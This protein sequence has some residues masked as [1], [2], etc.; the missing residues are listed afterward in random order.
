[1]KVLTFYT[2]RYRK[3]PIKVERTREKQMV[4][5]NRHVPFETVTLTTL[6]RNIELLEDILYNGNLM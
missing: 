6:G 4:D 5:Q 3:Y 2:I 1:M